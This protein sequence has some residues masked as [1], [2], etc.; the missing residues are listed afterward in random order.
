MQYPNKIALFRY[1]VLSKVLIREFG[2]EQRSKAIKAVAQ[3]DHLTDDRQWVKVSERSIYRWLNLYKILGWSGLLPKE[4]FKTE[5]SEVLSEDFIGFVKQQKTDDP[6]TSVPELIRR[7]YLLG[8]I[9]PHKE[10]NRVTVWRCLN[11]MGID[12]RR[13]KAI[14]KQL[15]SH[16]FAYPHRMNMVLCDGKHFRAGINRLKRVALI[17]LDDATRKALHVVVGTSED[18]DLFLK[19]LFET[20]MQHGLMIA[21]FVDNGPG[22]ISSDAIDVLQKLGV[23]FIHG[24]AGYPEGH[25][26]IE[27]F[28][29]TLKEQ[30]LRYIDANP[31]VD[32][33]CDALTL[34][35]RHYVTAQ[36]NQAPH[37][38][39]GQTSPLCRFNQDPNPLRFYK[40]QD[41]LRQAFVLHEKRKVAN[42][43]V[44]SYQGTLYEVM[45]GYAGQKIILHRNL[46][47]GTVSMLDQGRLVKLSPVDLHANARLK[48]VNPPK[49]DQDTHKKLPQSSA[50]MN[51]NRNFR[52]IVGPDGD[53]RRIDND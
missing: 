19:G 30:A 9:E 52:P 36:Y 16:R 10:V 34:R 33:D 20:I 45:P 11:R 3:L 18:T 5:T 51:F 23:L 22:F 24:T 42:D 50:E 41:Q 38:S 4:R 17:F 13:Q 43:N 7:A 39:L 2:G 46:L 21:L 40:N 49:T 53:F 32:S 29:R 25:G 26:K 1:Q 44:I 47:D 35:L 27:R 15:D 12:T 14:K 6:M 28:N 37:E 48:R 31:E 8:L